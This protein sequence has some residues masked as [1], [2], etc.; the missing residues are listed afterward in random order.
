MTL[1]DAIDQ[2]TQPIN[3]FM[4]SLSGYVW[5]IGLALA[6][7]AGVFFLFRFRGVQ[8]V[9]IPE[10]LRMMV[11]DARERGDGKKVSSFQA[12]CL[13]LGQRIGIGNIVGV[14]TAILLGGPGAIFWMWIFAL[15][16]AATSFVECTLGQIF[17]SRDS[18]GRLR[19]GPAFY[20]SNGLKNHRLAVFFAVWTVITYGIGFVAN[21]SAVSRGSFETIFGSDL[22]PI[23]TAVVL[24]LLTAYLV[25]GGMHRISR[26]A[27][28]VVPVMALGWM[29]LTLVTVVMNWHLIDDVLMLILSDAFDL[30]KIA[31]GFTGS[32]IM[33]GIKRGVFA[34][35]AGIGSIPSVASLSDVRH[36]V[37]QG[38]LQ[39][40]GVLVDTLVICSASAFMILMAFPE[41][42]GLPYDADSGVVIVEDAMS[43][44]LGGD[45]SKYILVA[46]IAVFG[47]TSLI[48]NYTVSESNLRFVT[49]S[50]RA[51]TAHRAMA[52][53]TV[54]IASMLPISLVWNS[55][56]VLM[57][58][59]TITNICVLF[60]L[61]RYVVSA[62]DDYRR[63]K[64]AGT[65]EP[66]FTF[67]VLERDG[68]DVS[69]VECWDPAEGLQG[70]R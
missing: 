42:L 58:V 17:K 65:D 47:F 2:A 4:L 64:D 48:G 31:A 43:M 30:T 36:P 32:C 63:Q 27:Q 69:G 44:L 46:F 16:G 41:G 15:L 67:E 9:R 28:Y 68:L 24:S 12:F 57:A 8:I 6:V 59:M 20:I 23:I 3:D 35:E 51:L 21:V 26:M 61:H 54:F 18:Q 1:Q 53:I 49:E 45:W 66:V 62:H 14:A 37:R 11:S 7:A 60:R 33:W 25:F 40:L 13:G 50:D 52:V 70:A 10:Q 39:S 34:N 22:V 56:D 29:L 19:G 38:Y 5:Y 55:V